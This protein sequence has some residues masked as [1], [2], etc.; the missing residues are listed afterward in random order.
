MRENVVRGLVTA[1]LGVAFAA[2]LLVAM[3]PA[4][5][6]NCEAQCYQGYTQCVRTC[7]K[8]P[9]FASCETVLEICLSNCG[10]GGSE[11]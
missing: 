8:N 7:S 1:V 10:S 9:C 2:G 4:V 5:A 6:D 11:S 3:T